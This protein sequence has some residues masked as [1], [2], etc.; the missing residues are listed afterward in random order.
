MEGWGVRVQVFRALFFLFK[1]LYDLFVTYLL[2]WVFL[3]AV[4]AFGLHH[5]A[6]QVAAGLGFGQQKLMW[7]RLSDWFGLA[8]HWTRLGVFAFG[9]VLFYVAMR[10]PI[11]LIKGLLERTSDDV[12]ESFD[13]VQP[14]PSALKALGG[15]VFSIIVTVLVVPFVI[16]PTIVPLRMDM[17]SWAKRAT[18]LVDG[19][20][21]DAVVESAVGLYRKVYASRY[22]QG[23]VASKD[24]FDQVLDAQNVETKG[25]DGPTPAP[26]PVGK[27]PMMDRW[28]PSIWEAVG[29]DPKGFAMTSNQ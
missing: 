6:D 25:L 8:P 5:L 20:A 13:Q 26:K 23:A 21:S 11:G 16:Q 15:L 29:G 1:G 12:G 14:K 2:G 27:Q 19:T 9:H 18:N 10:K 24:D 3:F 28:N 22:D 4:V 7:I 17:Q